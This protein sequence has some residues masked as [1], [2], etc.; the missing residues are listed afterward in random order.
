MYKNGIAVGVGVA[1]NDDFTKAFRTLD[2]IKMEEIPLSDAAELSK[3][4]FGL[5]V[6]SSKR[7]LGIISSLGRFFAKERDGTDGKPMFKDY[8]DW[9]TY[10]G[11]V[12][13]HGKRVGEGKMTYESGNYYEGGFFNNKFHG[14]RGIYHWE[15]G[16]EYLGGW[17]DGERHGVGSFKNAD[18][19]IEF[20]MYESDKAVGN[21]VRLS[22]DRKLAHALVDGE[23]TTEMPIE[24]ANAIV[25]ESSVQ[26]DQNI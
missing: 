2:G 13:E 22:A 26:L 15:D 18:G 11:Y 10:D 16:D 8:G 3:S 5:P 4:K 25:K 21:G 6:P 9:G 1:W 7:Q 17:K 14:D 12:D 24:E 23:Q 19:S 20:S